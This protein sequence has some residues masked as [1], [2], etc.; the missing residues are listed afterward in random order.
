MAPTYSQSVQ[1]SR[2]FF[3]NML[4]IIGNSFCGGSKLINPNQLKQKKAF[5]KKEKWD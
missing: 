3:T 1:L 4:N 5:K 2:T